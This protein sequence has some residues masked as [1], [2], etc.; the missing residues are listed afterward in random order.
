MNTKLIT[1][2]GAAFALT[3]TFAMA[4]HEGEYED[5]ARVRQVTPEYERVNVPRKECYSEWILE[6]RR[7]RSSLTGP[8]IGGVAG[9]V[10]GSHIGKGDGRVVA[11]AVGAVIGA[12]V[13]DNI[14]AH[15]RDDDHYE[16]EVRRCRMVDNWEERITSY[17]VVYEYYGRTYNAVLPFDPGSRLTVNVSV[18]PALDREPDREPERRVINNAPVHGQQRN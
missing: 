8:L 11:S 16:R 17:R 4:G 6:R 10:I 14:Q 18:A 7:H 13:G 3:S 1:A 15:H 2:L 9:G 12:L 5:F